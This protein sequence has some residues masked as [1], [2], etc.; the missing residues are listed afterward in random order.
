MALRLSRVMNRYRW[1]KELSQRQLS[2]EIGLDGTAALSHI[3]RGGMPTS[4]NLAKIVIWLLSE[5][6]D[7][8]EDV[9]EENEIDNC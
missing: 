7:A 1:A 4:G 2:E 8:T 9:P 3:E 5:D 6:P